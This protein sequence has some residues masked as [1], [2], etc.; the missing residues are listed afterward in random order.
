[1]HGLPEVLLGIPANEEL[2]LLVG[3][4]GNGGDKQEGHTRF[5]VLSSPSVGCPPP[6]PPYVM[7]RFVGGDCGLTCP[8]RSNKVCVLSIDGMMLE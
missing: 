7:L 4:H 5:L 2:S 1:M 8:S 3:E 6:S